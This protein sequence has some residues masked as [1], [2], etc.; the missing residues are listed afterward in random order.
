M[1]NTVEPQLSGFVGTRRNS[2]WDNWDMNINEEQKL[3]KLRKQH[4]IVKQSIYKSFGKKDMVYIFS[5]CY[6]YTYLFTIII[7]ENWPKMLKCWSKSACLKEEHHVSIESYK[8][9]K[10]AFTSLFIAVFFFIFYFFYNERNM[11]T[12]LGH[13][14]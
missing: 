5:V 12:D 9:H 14:Q 4:L 11:A 3:I 1:C 6:E 2:L 7:H 8:Q 13:D 10:L